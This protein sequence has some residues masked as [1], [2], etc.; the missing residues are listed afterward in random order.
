MMH[1]MIISSLSTG[2]MMMIDK[3]NTG[4]KSGYMVKFLLSISVDVLD[5]NA[6]FIKPMSSKQLMATLW[7]DFGMGI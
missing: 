7:Q 3:F 1:H 5:Q 4:Y 6:I 2:L